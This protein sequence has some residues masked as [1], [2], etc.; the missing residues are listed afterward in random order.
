MASAGSASDHS[1]DTTETSG[2]VTD[3]APASPEPAAGASTM[4]TEDN[5]SPMATPPPS[6]GINSHTVEPIKLTH[7]GPKF[8]LILNGEIQVCRLN[9][10]RTIVSKIM[11][12]KYLRRWESH[13]IYL[14]DAEIRSSTVSVVRAKGSDSWQL[15]S[16]TMFIDMVA[17]AAF[18]SQVNSLHAGVR[19]II[20]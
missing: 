9:H 17:H 20:V 2:A 13:H 14:D 16:A 5:N 4:T 1:T 12:S 11:N 3:A 7:T 10:T 15:V 18:N 6:P 19:F 8:K